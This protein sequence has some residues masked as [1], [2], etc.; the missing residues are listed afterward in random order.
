MRY[1]LSY[2]TERLSFSAKKVNTKEELAVLLQD[3]SK[4]LTAPSKLVVGECDKCH[5]F[6]L[7]FEDHECT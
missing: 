4:F 1:E 6:I 5:E 7:E 3:V 2:G